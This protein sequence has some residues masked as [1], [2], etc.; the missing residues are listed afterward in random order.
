[1]WAKE[2]FPNH[3]VVLSTQVDKEQNNSVVLLLL[4]VLTVSIV[5]DA[6]FSKPN[7]TSLNKESSCTDCPTIKWRPFKNILNLV[8]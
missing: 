5:S 8:S 1:M 7:L 6:I 3:G 2:V 4:L